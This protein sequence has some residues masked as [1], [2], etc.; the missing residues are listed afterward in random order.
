MT[1]VERHLQLGIAAGQVV[2][3]IQTLRRRA[4]TDQ[5]AYSL[6]D[7]E[8]K[9]RVRQ[10]ETRLKEMTGHEVAL[11]LIEFGRVTGQRVKV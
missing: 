1:A 5:G 2:F 7:P 10:A 11:A 4:L 8:L 9:M 3:D 6:W